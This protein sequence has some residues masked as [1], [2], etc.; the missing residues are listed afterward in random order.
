MPS[1]GQPKYHD[2]R[3]ECTAARSART[4]V[5]GIRSRSV[6][7]S[8]EFCRSFLA[9]ALARNEFPTVEEMNAAYWLQM[10]RAA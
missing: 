1:P 4:P 8:A 2:T 3:D 7:P 10:A 9:E 5:A 6:S